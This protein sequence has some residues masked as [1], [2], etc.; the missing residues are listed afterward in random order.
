MH[1]WATD[2]SGGA[3]SLE[4][5]AP[6]KVYVVVNGVKV[7][8]ELGKVPVSISVWGGDLSDVNNVNVD[9]EGRWFN[10]LPA[11]IISYAVPQS[12]SLRHLVTPPASAPTQS[13]SPRQLL[14]LA[15]ASTDLATGSEGQH[16]I[17]AQA[18]G[19]APPTSGG[20]SGS[21]LQGI[22]YSYLA[23]RLGGSTVL[24]PSK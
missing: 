14:L 24:S 22:P 3:P 19:G 18:R 10:A 11:C 17:S 12:L 9:A 21:T 13:L 20:T 8:L 23:R 1:N 15:S 4:F 7:H 6:T 2:L 5:V 16:A